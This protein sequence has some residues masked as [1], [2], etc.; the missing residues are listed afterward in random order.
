[1]SKSSITKLDDSTRI[2]RRCTFEG[3]FVGFIAIFYILIQGV[4]G[5]AAWT[6]CYINFTDAR[7]ALMGSPLLLAES[8]TNEIHKNVQIEINFDGGDADE[9]TTN[10]VTYPANKVSTIHA[11]LKVPP[12][13]E[14]KDQLQFAIDLISDGCSTT[15]EH[16]GTKFIHPSKC[17]GKRADAIGYD[18]SVEFQIDGSHS[19]KPV[20]LVAAWALGHEQVKVT[21]SITLRSDGAENH[22]QVENSNQGLTIIDAFYYIVI[23]IILYVGL[24]FLMRL[25]KT[26]KDRAV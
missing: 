6:K 19:T 24:S 9:W 25:K 11:R 18:T 26:K 13:L 15:D 17:E 2:L 21:R 16:C 10:D 4:D 14:E 22:K 5:Y 1:M 23:F 3:Y 12:Q 8:Q 20:Q 7:E